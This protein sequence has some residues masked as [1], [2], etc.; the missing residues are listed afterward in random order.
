[1][2]HTI[3]DAGEIEARRGVF[4]PIRPALGV[5]AFGINQIQLPPGGES[6][7]HD[8]AGDGQEEVYDHR[9]QRDDPR[10]GRRARAPARPLRLPLARRE[11]PARRRAGRPHLDR[12]RV[13][14][15]RVRAGELLGASRLTFA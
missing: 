14:A 10:R 2:A 11:A 4:K 3:V 12:R 9:R 6:F 13:E 15:R 8:H 5:T 1:M 7:E